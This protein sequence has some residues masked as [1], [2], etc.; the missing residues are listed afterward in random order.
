MVPI[1][2][3]RKGNALAEMALVVTSGGGPI[4]TLSELSWLQ[5]DY[6]F[7]VVMSQVF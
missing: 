1:L 7:S 6:P 2:Y 3:I 4:A 5:H